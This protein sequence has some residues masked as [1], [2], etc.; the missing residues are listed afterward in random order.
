MHVCVW[1]R[2]VRGLGC[3]ECLGSRKYGSSCQCRGVWC[4][5]IL[6]KNRMSVV[7]EVYGVCGLHI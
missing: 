3:R 7:S 1:C 5:W 6:R 2:D 4:L